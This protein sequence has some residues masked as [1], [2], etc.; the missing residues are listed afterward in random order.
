M[1]EVKDKIVTVE[2]LK[3]KHDYDENAYLKKSGALTTLGITA[4][5][6]ELNKLDGVTAT[7]SLI[8]I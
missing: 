1:A 7:L 2:S 3:A 4:T 8:H 5:A 6:S